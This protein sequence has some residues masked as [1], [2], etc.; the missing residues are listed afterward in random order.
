MTLLYGVAEQRVFTMQHINKLF[1]FAISVFPHK[2]LA[3]FYSVIIKT[4][5]EVLILN[6][7]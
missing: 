1:T 7:K 3:S 4:T 2:I 6:M 5:T